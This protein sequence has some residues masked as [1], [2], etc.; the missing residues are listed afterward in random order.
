MKVKLA[1]EL[2]IDEREWRLIYGTG[3]RRPGLDNHVRG[4]VHN[5][6]LNCAAA[7]EG[8]I[9]AATVTVGT[10]PVAPVAPDAVIEALEQRERTARAAYEE[11]RDRIA[12]DDRADYPAMSDEE[13]TTERAAQRTASARWTEAQEAL[14]VVRGLRAG[15]TT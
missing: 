9:R 7:E 15:C 3:S 13:R 5:L 14:G 4:Y 11:I 6:L 12:E 2:D 8:G 1:A 10:A